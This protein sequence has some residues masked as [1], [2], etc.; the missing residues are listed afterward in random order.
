MKIDLGKLTEAETYD[1]AV[2]CFN[3][4]STELQEKFIEEVCRECGFAITDGGED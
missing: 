2:D 3:N 4:L 1:L